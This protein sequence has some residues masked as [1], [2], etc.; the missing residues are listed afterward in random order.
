MV[1]SDEDEIEAKNWVSLY[2]IGANAHDIVAIWNVS[3]SARRVGM[4]AAA[5]ASRSGR[6]WKASA[7]HDHAVFVRKD[8]TKSW[9]VRRAADAIA[10]SNGSC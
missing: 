4:A 5:R 2:L 9:I 7:A 6:W 8:G 10:G 3:K 1:R